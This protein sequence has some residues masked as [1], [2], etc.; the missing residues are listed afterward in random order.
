LD[1]LGF[2]MVREFAQRASQVHGVP[3]EY[4]IKVLA[5]NCTAS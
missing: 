5:L 1:T 3:E 2:A 4:R